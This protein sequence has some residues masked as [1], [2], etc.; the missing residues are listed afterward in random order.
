MEREEEAATAPISGAL[1]GFG[2][3]DANFL[4]IQPGH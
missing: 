2:G 3:P 4:L 1:L